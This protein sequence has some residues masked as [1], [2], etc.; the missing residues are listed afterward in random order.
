MPVACDARQRART[1]GGDCQAACDRGAK[2]AFRQSELDQP[3]GAV[4][5]RSRSPR[6]PRRTHSSTQSSRRRRR[7]SSSRRL[8]SSNRKSHGSASSAASI[9]RS[10]RRAGEATRRSSTRGLADSCR[11]SAPG[12]QAQLGFS[13]FN[14]RRPSPRSA[15][16]EADSATSACAASIGR[17]IAGEVAAIF[18]ASARGG[19]C[20]ASPFELL[21]A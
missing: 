7:S 10:R 6:R 21:R 18:K 1:Q 2:L 17:D 3:R 20:M 12:Q 4:D 19:Q 14:P 15:R 8:S 11:C 16:Y 5:G 9:A 13:L